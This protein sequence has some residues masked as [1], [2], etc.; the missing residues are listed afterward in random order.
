MAVVGLAVAP[1]LHGYAASQTPFDKEVLV[2]IREQLQ[3][4]A[5][6]LQE[7]VPRKTGACVVMRR[8]ELVVPQAGLSE[9]LENVRQE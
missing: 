8:V 4:D 2:D 6:V 9:V 5:R 1:A 3:V 7:G